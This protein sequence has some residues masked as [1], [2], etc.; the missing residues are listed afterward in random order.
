MIDGMR[1]GNMYLS[2]NLTN[3]SLSPLLYDEVN[4]SFSGQIRRVGHQRRPDERDPEIGRQYL[5]AALSWRMDPGRLSR[6]A[7]KARS[8][9][10][11]E[12]CA[13]GRDSL[14]TL[15]DIN[16]AIGGPIKKDALWFSFTS[17]YFTNGN[18]WPGSTIR[19]IRP[20]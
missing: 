16:G 3:M 7:M 9:L 6:R 11:G 13:T 8:R 15:Y 1:I 20:G 17:R 2:S 5:P 12:G 19:S 4:I 18:T 14:K 10:Q